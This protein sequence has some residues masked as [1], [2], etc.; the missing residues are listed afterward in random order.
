MC[1]SIWSTHCN[2]VNSVQEVHLLGQGTFVGSRLFALALGEDSFGKG[3]SAL[4]ILLH[5][6]TSRNEQ[7]DGALRRQAHAINSC[8][9]LRM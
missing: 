4:I 2:M 8:A 3:L 6:I 9:S 7:L 1:L 5:Q